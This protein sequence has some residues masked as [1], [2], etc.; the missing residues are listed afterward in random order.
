MSTGSESFCS[1]SWEEIQRVVDLLGFDTLNALPDSGRL[2]IST[3]WS[4]ANEL[5][6]PAVIEVLNTL[7]FVR[8]HDSEGC[9]E[10]KWSDIPEEARRFILRTQNIEME[11]PDD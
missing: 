5:D 8:L 7:V 11:L 6:K 10:H 9:S 4:G 2:F 1:I 3:D